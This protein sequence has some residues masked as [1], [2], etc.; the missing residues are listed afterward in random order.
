MHIVMTGATAGI[1]LVAAQQLI[2]AGAT[3]AIGARSPS[4]APAALA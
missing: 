3:M 1:G 4:A 2:A